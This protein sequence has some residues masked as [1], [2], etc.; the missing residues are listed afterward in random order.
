M[1]GWDGNGDFSVTYNWNTDK[2]N[3]I[4]ITA[5]RM[6]Q[7]TGVDIVGGL[8]NCRT[9]DGQNAPSAALPMATYNHTNVGNATARNQYLTMGQYQDNGGVYFNSSGSANAYVLSL[10]PAIQNYTAGQEFVFN[11]N[12]ANT[13]SATID[14]SGLG[15]KTLQYAGLN[16]VGGEID[17]G[18]IVKIVYDGTNFQILS[19]LNDAYNSLKLLL[20]ME[21]LS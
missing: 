13:G 17:S 7:V 6:E 14:V 18:Q 12:F 3:S 11:A 15:A 20:N 8:N 21:I 4:P 16:L 10:S 1:P 19:N 2:A 5:S 9:L